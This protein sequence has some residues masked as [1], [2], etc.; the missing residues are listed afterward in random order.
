MAGA[1]RR[2]F[3]LLGLCS[4]RVADAVDVG[5][6]GRHLIRGKLRATH[7][8]HGAT[9]LFGLCYTLVDCFLDRRVAAIAPQPFLAGE[10][11]TK[12]RTLSAFTVATRA[13][14]SAHLAAIDAFTERY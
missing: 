5:G 7:R 11:G 1:A 3:S 2:P 14:C 12:R 8:R 4:R 10:S 9:E 6:D 13:C